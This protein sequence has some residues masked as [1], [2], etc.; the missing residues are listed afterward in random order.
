[1]RDL[2]RPQAVHHL[3]ELGHELTRTRPTQIPALGRRTVLG[4]RASQIG[5]IGFAL[6]NLLA[7]VGQLRRSGL[8]AELWRHA[9][10]DVAGAGLG[11]ERIGQAGLSLVQQ[12][13]HVKAGRAAQGASD[14]AHAQRARRI[15]KQLG[16]AIGGA[17]AELA[18]VDLLGRIGKLAGQRRKIATSPRAIRSLLGARLPLADLCLGRALGHQHQHMGQV[19]L[20]LAQGDTS[21]LLSDV[22]VNIGFADLRAALHLALA[23]TLHQDLVAQIAAQPV[24]VHP[25]GSQPAA[26]VGQRHLVL[27]GDRFLCLRQR[28][29][30]DLNAQ[31]AGLL[32]L[33][34]L[35]HQLFK[36]LG[37]QFGTRRHGRALL[38]DLLFHPQQAGAHLVVGD[39]LGIDQRHDEIHRARAAD[40]Q[41]GGRCGGPERELARGPQGLRLRQAGAEQ[42]SDQQGH[43]SHRGTS[44]RK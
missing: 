28:G 44:A 30:V 4:C 32:N 6:G 14:V 18:T 19:E 24:G 41:R 3:L 26:E 29:L 33:H 27:R 22:A 12:L 31:F 38:G 36:H 11:H 35:G 37:H 34:A 23:Q 25:F 13:E 8:C 2:A 15:D 20:Q 7:V 5:E 16:Q 1:M 21:A 39:G 40:S 42:R 17:Q 43:P 9:Q 10:Q